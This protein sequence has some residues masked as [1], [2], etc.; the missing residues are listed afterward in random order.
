MEQRKSDAS[1]MNT[2]IDSGV[3][4]FDPKTF[5]TEH[6]IARLGA[7]SVG[8]KAAGLQQIQNEILPRFDAAKF[9]G[10]AVELPRA[11]VI[12]TPAATTTSG[13]AGHRCA[14]TGYCAGGNNGQ[15]QRRRGGRVLWRWRGRRG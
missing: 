8:G 13:S 15:R 14:G 1:R 11:V 2:T 10:I 3:P 6:S 12:A 4:K 7:G 5:G 9:D